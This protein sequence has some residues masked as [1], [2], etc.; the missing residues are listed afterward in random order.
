[1]DPN[2]TRENAQSVV[3]RP[4]GWASIIKTTNINFLKELLITYKYVALSDAA[5]FYLPY[6]IQRI[7]TSLCFLAK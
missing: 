1:V 3:A 5:L 2:T 6:N 7:T 4:E